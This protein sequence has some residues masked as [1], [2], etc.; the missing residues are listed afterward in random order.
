M[1]NDDGFAREHVLPSE[2]QRIQQKTLQVFRRL[3]AFLHFV[4]NKRD[5]SE[6][7]YDQIHD[8]FIR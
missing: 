3:L 8:G 1:T 5:I 7:K 2:Q 6:A 4:I